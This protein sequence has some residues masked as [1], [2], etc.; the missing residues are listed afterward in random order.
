VPRRPYRWSWPRAGRRLVVFADVLDDAGK[1]ISGVGRP[2]NAHYERNIR[3][4]RL[5]TSSCSSRSPLR[6]AARPSS[7]ASIKWASYSNSWSTASSTNWA[8]SWPVRVANWRSRASLSG[9]KCTSKCQT[10][11]VTRIGSQAKPPAPRLSNLTT[12]FRLAMIKGF[13]ELSLLLL[14]Y[15]RFC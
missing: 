3:S 10:G 9:E 11:A 12:L 13:G 6:A 1:V 15:H 4:M 2:S 5:T 7:T 8:A 14:C